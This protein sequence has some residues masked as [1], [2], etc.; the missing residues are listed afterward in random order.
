RLRVVADLAAEALREDRVL[1]VA[2]AMA[3]VT[4]LLAEGAREAAAGRPN[5]AA[6]RFRAAH[7]AALEE[8][9]L[10]GSGL[11]LRLDALAAELADL[12]KGVALVRDCA[13]KVWARILSAGERGSCALLAAL[14]E[15]RGLQCLEL[16]PAEVLICAGD[17][18]E[19]APRRELIR[20]R[21]AAYHAS[22]APLALLPGF[23]GGD[24]RGE[25]MLLGR[26]GSDF[27]AALAA[28]AVDARLLEIWTDVD[29][30]HTA[31]P[32]LVPDA[33]FLAEL[34]YEE[35]MELAHFGAKVLHPRTLLPVRDA[36]IPLRVRNS[37]RPEAPGTLVR[38]PREGARP[39]ARGITLLRDAALLDLSGPGL[40]GVPSVAAKAF[41]ALAARDIAV[42]LVTQGSSECSLTLCLRDADLAAAEE[43]LQ[44]A[45]E[46][47][48]AAGLLEP[49]RHRRG[50]AIL[51]LV[52]DGMRHH[53][54][55][56][57]ALF[58]SLGAAGCNVVAIAQG[59]SERSISAVVAAQDADRALVAAHCRFFGE[60]GRLD[61]CLM[62][63]GCVGGQLLEL[64]A[65][66]SRHGGGSDLRL[67]AVA[68]SKRMKLDPKGLDPAR[69][70]AILEAEGEPLD[71]LRLRAF[72]AAQGGTPVM[73]DCTSSEGLSDAYEAFVEA[74]FHLVAA[75]KKMSSGPL[76]RLRQVRA[77]LARRKRRFLNETSVGAGLPVLAPLQ[78]LRSAGD[79]LRRVEGV[80]SGSL[81][82][83]CGLLEE[84]VPLSEAVRQ[85]RETGTTEPDP[86][87]DLSG[88]DVARK[89][90]ILHRELGGALELEQVAVEGLLPAGFDASGSVEQFMENLKALDAPFRLRLQTLKAEGRV[91]RFVA[92]AD[93]DGCGAGP[94]W[95]EADHPLASVRGGENALSVSTAAY[96]PRPLVVRGYG[97]GARVTALGVLGDVLKLAV[98]P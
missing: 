50:L 25:P 79:E 46:A 33:G 78:E 48:L 5:D 97:A 31:D 40:R 12:F 81:S 27:S 72:A 6:P 64:L 88:L 67:C 83:I 91:L 95:L 13:P 14:L 17:P 58:G 22:G 74:G 65:H 9:G 85:A 35:A 41:T 47:E 49:V 82:L 30:V 43:A 86:R 94:R 1:L 60:P 71:L 68:N 80:L 39:A 37:L 89:A 51:S 2:S 92:A 44:G 36:G 20:A 77:A 90:L 15:S 19:A 11:T 75:N 18:R 98:A 10:G 26:G 84:G 93:K 53:S 16:D 66:R 28:A 56:C 32:R 96:S 23:F 73:V 55:V 87:E 3:G 38:A 76:P 57:G 8:L 59:S 29:G 69:A 61:L 62:G 42:V 52:G 63:V 24:E 54:G 21:L 70:K 7:Q 4:D 34:S 45:F